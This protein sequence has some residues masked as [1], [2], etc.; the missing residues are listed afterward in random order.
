MSDLGLNKRSEE[1]E[2]ED[3][4][5]EVSRELE[6]SLNGMERLKEEVSN[7]LSRIAPITRDS[8]PTAGRAE[9]LKEPF[10]STTISQKV[11]SLGDD[12]WEQ[13]ERIRYA[14]TRIEL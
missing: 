7:L 11:G 9:K 10:R 2:I 1:M 3:R 6:N 12:I 8:G 4:V 5:P 13:V 14:I